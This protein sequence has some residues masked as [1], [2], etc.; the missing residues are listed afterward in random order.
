MFIMLGYDG[1]EVADLEA[2]VEHLKRAEPGRLPDHRRLPDQGHAVPRR[3]WPDRVAADAALGGSA[4]TATWAWPAGTRGASTTTRPAGWSTR[5][6]STGPAGR[7]RPTGRGMGRMYLAARRGRLGHVAGRAGSARTTASRRRR[8][9]AG[10]RTSGASPG[11][12]DEPAPAAALQPALVGRAASRCC[13]CRCWRS[14]RALEGR[15]DYRIVDGNLEAR[16][17]GA[18]RR[19]GPRG[20]RRAVLGVTVMPGPQLE[21]AVP[22]CRELKRRHPG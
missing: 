22:L 11:R 1:E 2:T 17:A 8:G 15:L 20:G 5:S 3:R 18:A 6:A 4:P 10:R 13:R 7:A 12:P 16:P 9:G 14:G 21:Q 19:G